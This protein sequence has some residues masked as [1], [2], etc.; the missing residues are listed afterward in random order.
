VTGEWLDSS[1][2]GQERPLSGPNPA[3]SN[4]LGRHLTNQRRWARGP[5]AHLTD[6]LHPPSPPSTGPLA[7]SVH[8][9]TRSGVGGKSRRREKSFRTPLILLHI[10]SVYLCTENGYFLQWRLLRPFQIFTTFELGQQRR[11]SSRTRMVLVAAGLEQPLSI[12]RVAML[13]DDP[14]MNSSAC[15]SMY[16]PSS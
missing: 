10:T 15:T 12:S 5:G 16:D 4:S 8:H 1:L 6:R 3:K 9:P 13:D 14:L 7:I 2:S 11:T